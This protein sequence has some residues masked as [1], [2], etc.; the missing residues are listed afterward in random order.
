MLVIRMRLIEEL[1][2][3]RR[4]ARSTSIEDHELRLCV[5]IHGRELQ[6]V[7]PAGLACNARAVLITLARADDEKLADIDPEVLLSAAPA[8][9]VR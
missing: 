7:Q 2:W 9:L 8:V 6:G 5:Q 4:R 3:R 1:S